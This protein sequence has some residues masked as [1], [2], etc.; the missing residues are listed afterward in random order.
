LANLAATHIESVGYISPAVLLASVA[1]ADEVLLLSEEALVPEGR[2][3]IFAS[4]VIVTGF[5][6]GFWFR[7]RLEG[8]AEEEVC[9]DMETALDR[10]C[11]VGVFSPKPALV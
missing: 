6:S 3:L 5:G 9:G 11:G 4:A 7:R 10:S 8:I 2:Q 1:N